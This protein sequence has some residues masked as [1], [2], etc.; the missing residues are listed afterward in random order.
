MQAYRIARVVLLLGVAGGLSA[1][2]DAGF[3]LFKKDD[4][5][6]MPVRAESS[7][8]AAAEGEEAEAPE[9]FHVEEAGLWDGRPSLGGIWVA[10]PDAADPERVLIRNS[11]TGQSVTGA[12]F[13]RERENP[14]P[15]LQ[16]S[17][18]AAARIGLL[19]GQ[20]TEIAVTALRRAPAPEAGGRKAE[21]AGADAGGRF[22]QVATL[23]SADRAEATAARLDKAGLSA[24]I[25]APDPGGQG[26]WRV[27]AGPAKTEADRAVL[28]EAVRGLG[29]D[30]AYAVNR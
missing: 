11:E 25:R 13:R 10:H 1:C 17:S 4:T 6:T 22:V 14:G 3:G 26:L 19:A 27:V 21:P 20:P 18:E 12:L 24:E 8:A 29:Y 30:D 9:V 2:Q 7:A 28:I 16:V 5:E 15:R 23:D